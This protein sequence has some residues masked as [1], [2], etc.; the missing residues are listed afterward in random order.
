MEE[1]E[2]NEDVIIILSESLEGSLNVL[3]STLGETVVDVF[4]FVIGDGAVL[5]A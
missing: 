1:L 2:V 3:R 5:V 4:H